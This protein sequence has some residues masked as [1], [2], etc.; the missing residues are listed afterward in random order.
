MGTTTRWER[1]YAEHADRV[2]AFTVR[3][4]PFEDVPDIVAE[5]F[6]VVGRREGDVPE[7]ALPW[8]YAVARNVIAN[9]RRSAARRQAL[10]G[11]LKAA[12]VPT[13]E[14]PAEFEAV[15]SREQVV[16]ALALLPAAEREALLL[17]A[18]EDLD[19]VRGA[20]VLGCSP[21]AFSV[22]VHR[23]KRRLRESL[24]SLPK[25]ES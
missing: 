20:K 19:P 24:G 6:V 13:P 4:V 14:V 22:R 8:L 1:L 9:H 23:A 11:R 2:F 16:E 15:E 25:E 21:G 12:G 7:D 17:V 3:R 10:R 5:T 18:W